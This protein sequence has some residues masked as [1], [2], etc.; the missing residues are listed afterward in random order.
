[1][2]KKS[3]S[4]RRRSGAPGNRP[5]PAPPRAATTPQTAPPSAAVDAVRNAPAAVS[6]VPA[7]AAPLVPAP[8]AEAAAAAPAVGGEPRRVGRIDPSTR[9]PLRRPRVAPA[10][11]LDP[12]DVGIPLARVPYA[13]AD[14]RRVGIMA[15]LM[16]A[17]IVVA[18]V[19][20]VLLVK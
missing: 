5:R 11:E 7:T 15:S 2:A 13:T 3:K 6:D 18:A 4:A 10:A 14:L 8:A 1:M 12:E 19:L 17:L 9:R 20:V 16:V